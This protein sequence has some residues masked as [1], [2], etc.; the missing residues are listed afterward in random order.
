MLLQRLAE[1]ADQL[2]EV[3]P[4][5][6]ARNNVRYE[7]H[8]DGAGRLLSQAPIDLA[9]KENKAGQKRPVPFKRRSGTQ[10]PPILL[11]DHAE[12]TLGL[13]RKDEDT[14]KAQVRH[15]VYLQ[16]LERCAE[17][18][19]DP[20]VSAVYTFLS[21]QPLAQLKLDDDFVA[22]GTIEFVVDGQRVTERASV[23]SFWAEYNSPDDGG[24]TMQCVVCRRWRPALERLPGVLKGIPGG[25]AT[26]TS[27]I[28]ANADAF[29]SYGLKA[30]HVAPI[31]AECAERFTNG[32][33]VL[34][35]DSLHR[36]AIDKVVYLFWS[37]KEAGFSITG[38]FG[39]P[40]PDKVRELI[41]AART[42]NFDAEMDPTPYYAVALTANN[43]RSVV[44]DWLDTTV[45]QV[46][47]SLGLWFI[48]QAIIGHDGDEA[49]PLKLYALAA[50]TVR[51]PKKELSGQTTVALLRSALTGVPLPNRLLQQVVRRC[52]V[53]RDVTRPQAALL[54]LVMLSNNSDYQ[55][56]FMIELQADHPDAAYHCGRL[57]A[58]LETIQRYAA[59]G[60]LNTT[61]VDRFYGTA[62]SAPASV[63][64]TLIRGAQPHITKLRKNKP[65][66]A[67]RL[68]QEMEEVLAAVALF[69]PILTVKQQAL[70][71]LGYY[72]QRAAGRAH[73][74]AIS[75]QKQR[76][77]AGAPAATS[78]IESDTIESFT[79][80]EA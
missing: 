67:V 7:I 18:T 79:G 80:D 36:L 35:A 11:A 25:N 54:K 39:A 78:E 23:R 58:V 13:L 45:G 22:N 38:L 66:L 59:D 37:Q 41:N 48:R 6:Y 72:H 26:G 29:E 20:A 10:P 65:G 77:T 60:Q 34:L 40:D 47:A 1:Y 3:L 50:A 51:D 2:E 49:A 8:L 76:Q 62:S 9:S 61:L 17:R 70:F 12:F 32:I 52:Q 5:G 43:A 63:F 14:A 73:A 53:T 21:S 31:C 28:S 69:P 16:L 33:N 68:E 42:A 46:K 4:T 24:E 15:A 19:Q 56:D 57:L 55:E 71:A 27:L 74:K 64:G 75:Q 30:S 44:R